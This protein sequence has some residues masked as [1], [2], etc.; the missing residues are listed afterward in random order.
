M[1]F[2]PTKSTKVPLHYFSDVALK[3]AQAFYSNAVDQL[4]DKPKNG[5][6]FFLEAYL[7]GINEEIAKRELIKEAQAYKVVGA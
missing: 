3:E 5:G 6:S 4:K 2:D 7:R 1:K